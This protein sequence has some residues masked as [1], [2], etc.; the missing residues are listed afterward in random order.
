MVEF[1]LLKWNLG[2][3]STQISENL[4]F[5]LPLILYM[6][7]NEMVLLKIPGIF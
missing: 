3:Q 1:S 6:R 4:H 2:F 7:K 5:P